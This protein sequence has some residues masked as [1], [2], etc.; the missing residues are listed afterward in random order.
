MLQLLCSVAEAAATVTVEDLLET[1]CL[2]VTCILSDIGALRD[3]QSVPLSRNLVA[4]IMIAARM[5]AVAAWLADWR[6][7]LDVL[8]IGD[9]L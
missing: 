6:V 5:V 3:A 8:L 9:I 7:V 2:A 1:G 4:G